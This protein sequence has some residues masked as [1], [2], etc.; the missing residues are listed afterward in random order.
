MIRALAEAKVD[1]TQKNNDGF[2]A[3]DVAE[4]KQPAASARGARRARRPAAGGGRGRGGRGG[5]AA[6]DVAKL[7][8]E[9]MGL[10]PAP[11]SLRTGTRRS[12]PTGARSSEEGASSPAR[13]AVR[14]RAPCRIVAAAVVG[15][16]G[17]A[18]S[19]PQS[20]RSRPR[21]AARRS[22]SRPTGAHADAP[23]RLPG[24][25]ERYCVGCHNDARIR[26]PPARRSRSTRPISPIPARTR[27]SGR[28]VVQ[29]ARRRRDAAAGIAD[30]RRTRS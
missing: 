21:T 12:R 11:R 28:R 15:D 7:L 22:R 18:D 23:T 26:F 4:G 1:F 5:A 10:P 27:P 25:A 2:T 16:A 9:L 6:Q 30:A 29:E 20:R 13:D 3:L 17:R 24:D 19:R 8:R 14:R